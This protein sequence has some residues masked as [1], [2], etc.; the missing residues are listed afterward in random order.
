MRSKRKPKQ[1][2]TIRLGYFKQVTFVYVDE[3]E[4]GYLDTELYVYRNPVRIFRRHRL[5]K[6]FYV[7]PNIP[8]YPIG[9]SKLVK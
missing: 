9:T 5:I 7:C 6:F 1:S 4:N 2:L 3:G 8:M